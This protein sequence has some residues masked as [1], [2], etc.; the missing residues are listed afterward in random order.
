[1]RGSPLLRSIFIVLLLIASA[2]VL[3]RL[4]SAQAPAETSQP[5][6]PAREKSGLQQLP[7]RLTFS[8]EVAEMKLS[9]GEQPAVSE[10]SG[11]LS[12]APG[13]PL[14]LTVR[15]KSAAAAG[16]HRFA[17]LVLEPAGKPTITHVFDADGDIDDVFELP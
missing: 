1:V 7:Y 4:T 3:V 8:A 16:E 11:T 15:W 5:T 12:A 13:S 14:F 6:A 2:V 17:K 10:A 9:A